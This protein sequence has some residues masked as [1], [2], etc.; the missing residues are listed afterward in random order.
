MIV[1]LTPNTGLDLN[2]VI[3]AYRAGMVRATRSRLSM[4]G[5]AIDAAYVLGQ[6]GTPSLALGFAA[7]WAGR[8]M[9]A[10][11]QAVGV[12]TAFTW[13]EGESRINPMITCEDGSGETTIGVDTLQVGP[14]HLAELDECLERALEGADCLA[15]G[16]SLPGGV[17]AQQYAGW[18]QTARRRGVPVVFDASGVAF[19]AGLQARPELIK[20]NRLE[21]EDLLGRRLETLAHIRQAARQVQ[22]EFGCQVVVSLGSEGV[23]AVFGREAY[24]AAALPVQVVSTAGAGDAL[25]AGCCLAMARDWPMIEGLRWGMAAAAAVVSQPWTAVCDP[26]DFYHWLPQV[27][28]V[29]LD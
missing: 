12:K 21:L 26:Q 23:L 2:V 6:M 11:L 19:A 13:V 8:R 7:G 5:K 25:L 9:E 22:A 27:Q 3:P 18:I 14:G 17:A 24:Q 15:L 29:Q 16:G 4:G 20:P 28:I 10:M 1:T